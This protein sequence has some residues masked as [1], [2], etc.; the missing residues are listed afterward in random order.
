MLVAM[1]Q[2]STGFDDLV[3]PQQNKEMLSAVVEMQSADTQ[4]TTVDNELNFVSGK[5]QGTLILLHGAPG[6]GKT[7]TAEAIA[8]RLHRPLF[9]VR[10][11]DLGS[12][13]RELEEN[14]SKFMNLAQ[15]WNCI[16]LLN[17][18]DVVVAARS[19]GDREGNNITT[20]E[21]SPSS[22][23]GNVLIIASSV[24]RYPGVL[25]RYLDINHQPGRRV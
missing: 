6:T 11:A 2:A 17:D 5:A 14:L 19:K 22:E 9:A 13:S 7:S 4:P 12:T 15:R 24:S 25:H 8:A 16:L 3:L 10:M 20:G 1:E 18:A 23:P 21:A